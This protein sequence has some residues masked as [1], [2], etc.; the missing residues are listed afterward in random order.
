MKGEQPV[1]QIDPEIRLRIEAL[2]PEEHV[3]DPRQRMNLYKRLS[4]ASENAEI[5]Q[6]EQEIVD[7]YGRPPQ[8]VSNLLQVM[9]I[10]L[11][12]KECMILRL[13]YNDRDLIV[14]FHPDTPIS[15][16]LLVSW[17]RSD[18]RNVRLVPEDRL[19]YR[20]GLVAPQVRIARCFFLL[21]ALRNKALG[22][23]AFPGAGDFQQAVEK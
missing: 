19:M 12:M 16:E 11:A 17:A 3:P 5:E 9:R 8:E 20:I 6:I 13:D 7:L 14:T 23:P 4:R 22:D 21:N 1:P 18:P 15:P 10:R 2:I